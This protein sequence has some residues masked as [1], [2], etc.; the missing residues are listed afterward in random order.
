MITTFHNVLISIEAKTPEA[1]YDLLC[2]LLTSSRVEYTTDTFTAHQYA[3]GG[4]T[5]STYELWPD[6]RQDPDDA[7]R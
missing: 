7:T 1:A 3:E 6:Q 2:E 5:K 4:T